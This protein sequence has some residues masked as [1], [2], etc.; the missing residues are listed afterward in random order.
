MIHLNSLIL[1]SS[2]LNNHI[3]QYLKLL[4]AGVDVEITFDSKALSKNWKVLKN[5]LI[6]NLGNCCIYAGKE[7][8]FLDFPKDFKHVVSHKQKYRINHTHTTGRY[9]I[10]T[11]GGQMTKE[12]VIENKK[13]LYNG[14][15]CDEYH[16]L[17]ND[18]SHEI[19][20]VCDKKD[21]KF[22]LIVE[23][24]TPP[25]IEDLFN[26]GEFPAEGW[27]L[28]EKWVSIDR[29]IEILQKL[30]EKVSPLYK[31]KKSMDLN[32]KTGLFEHVK[33]FYFFNL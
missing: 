8:F 12:W 9:N 7:I 18:Y 24:S 22:T 14:V 2:K 31:S 27:Y 20:V 33:S 3:K 1:E 19:S 13:K 28:K 4:K 21:S 29:L 11:N 26:E 15:G 30:D 25:L 10:T 6:P 16:F 23:G 32:D 17:M 5:Y